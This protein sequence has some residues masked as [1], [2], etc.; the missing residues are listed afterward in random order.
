MAQAPDLKV[1]MFFD[2]NVDRLKQMAD[3]KNAYVCNLCSLVMWPTLCVSSWLCCYYKD[4]YELFW[5]SERRC[6]WEC[7]F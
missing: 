2:Q 7:G 6:V 4:V 3:N 1:S 5:L